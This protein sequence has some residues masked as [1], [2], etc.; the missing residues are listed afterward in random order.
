MFK[1]IKN[2]KKT[3]ASLPRRKA[4]ANLKRL[5]EDETNDWVVITKK[6]AMQKKQQLSIS[7]FFAQMRLNELLSDFDDISLY[8]EM[9]SEDE[10]DFLGE[11]LL[12]QSYIDA[13]YNEELY[14]EL[15]IK[16]Q[17]EQRCLAD[18]AER[19]FTKQKYANQFLG[20]EQELTDMI[21]QHNNDNRS[22]LFM[23]NQQ[24]N[25]TTFSSSN[26]LLKNDDGTLSRS[27]APS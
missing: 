21:Q 22:L 10:E 13:N 11:D 24:N 16:H 19:L 15:I 14:G 9:P 18:R 1:S 5:I 25:P 7:E 27:I 20:T 17:Q 6:E 2:T 23:T 26:P 8:N 4:S 3:K 12:V